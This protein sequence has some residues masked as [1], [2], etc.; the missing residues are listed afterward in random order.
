M[1]RAFRSAGF[2][3]TATFASQQILPS[4]RPVGRRFCNAV[5]LYKRTAVVGGIALARFDLAFGVDPRKRQAHPTCPDQ[6]DK[7]LDRC[8]SQMPNEVQRSEDV[9]QER[10][11]PHEA[12]HHE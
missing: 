7:N 2:A 8:R 3:V 9:E 4:N 10:P 1:I 12:F 6:G 5:D 11:T